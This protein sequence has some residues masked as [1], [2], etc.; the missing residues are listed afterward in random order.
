MIWMLFLAC[1]VAS[2]ATWSNK[3]ENYNFPIS[4][5]QIYRSQAL[6]TRQ[7]KVSIN[8]GKSYIVL[9]NL[10]AGIIDQSIRVQLPDSQDIKI[11]EIRTETINI[12]TF[13]TKNAI[14][15]NELLIT[16]QNNLKELSDTYKALKQEEQFLIGLDFGKTVNKN[17][18]Q[19]YPIHITSWKNAL[20]Y[21]K[22]SLRKNHIK[23]VQMLSKI[24]RAREDLNVAL[25]IAQRYKSESRKSYKEIYLQL[26]AQTN[27]KTKIIVSY[28][29]KGAYWYPVYTARMSAKNQNQSNSPVRLQSFALVKNETGE[30]WQN[31]RLSFSAA[32]PSRQLQFLALKSWKI[33]PIER[34]VSNPSISSKDTESTINATIVQAEKSRS[35]TRNNKARRTS[36]VLKPKKKK[37]V[38]YQ[39]MDKRD[40]YV[41]KSLNVQLDEA[42]G[43]YIKNK[44][45]IGLKRSKQRSNQ[46]EELLNNYQGNLVKRNRAHKKGDFQ[47]SLQYNNA[48]LENINNI[49]LRFQKYFLEDKKKAMESRATSLR[50]IENQKYLGKLKNPEYTGRGFDFRFISPSKESILS[51][52][53]FHKIF[54]KENKFQAKLFYESSPLNSHYS[55]LTGSMKNS[56]DSPILAG[57]VSVF[58]KNNYVGESNLG[59]IN[60][61]QSF[62]LNL[63]N[64]ENIKISRIKNSYRETE[65]L[66][67]AKFKYKNDVIINIKNLNAYPVQIRI[68]E[69]I[70]VATDENVQIENI[71]FSKSPV[72][73]KK[74]LGLYKFIITLLPMERK[75]IKMQFD[76]IHPKGYLP[77]Y[78]TN[79]STRW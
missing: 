21:R 68:Y 56:Q 28:R 50:M 31:T 30:K 55:F 19:S 35:V 3:I 20:E 72:E 64:D 17:F 77:S 44:N 16:A 58:F 36:R 43:Y 48:I 39:R 10:P 75:T 66:L 2:Q 24:D 54:I 22:E 11:R 51:D 61:K 40:Q 63:G 38:L 46:S 37:Q 69:R 4:H 52:G 45:E 1:L 13:K 8:K 71:I 78:N 60:K 27:V 9:K 47:S 26:F 23:S 70:P 42:N 25:T 49:P 5:V 67:T 29:I 14:E 12:A 32:N 73:S 74:S 41:Q 33:K 53:S 76:M 7:D 34:A 15:A 65:G 62:S 57:P 6:V 18:K 79:N 59:N